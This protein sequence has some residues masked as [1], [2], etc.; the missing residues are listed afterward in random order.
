MS[1]NNLGGPHSNFDQDDAAFTPLRPGEDPDAWLIRLASSSTRIVTPFVGGE[2][3]W[4]TWGQ[5]PPLMLV[6]G[7]HG[8][9]RHWALNILSLARD[10]TVIAPDLPGFGASDLPVT[11][12]HDAVSAAFFAGLREVAGPGV[13]VDVAAFSM[14]GVFSAELAARFPERVKRLVLVDTG[15]LGTPLGDIKMTRVKGL[16][17]EEA[18]AAH[19]SNLANLMLSSETRIDPLAVHIQADGVAAAR[20]NFMPLILPHRLLDALE[21]ARCDIHAIW[22]ALDATHPDPSAQE[23]VLRG[24]RAKMSFKVIPDAGHWV[25]YERPAAF[26]RALREIL[27]RD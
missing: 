25:M 27:T 15:G 5:G 18:A 16:Q 6:H 13:A 8:S 10:W 21:R 19:R 2:M 4:R 11:Q 20:L 7:S 23:R 22:G 3:V 1:N 9:W 24:L 14:G 26:E 17:G 12:D